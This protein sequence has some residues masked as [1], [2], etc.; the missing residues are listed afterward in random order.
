MRTVLTHEEY[1]HLEDA[2]N[3]IF[4]Q[5]PTKAEAR[6]NSKAIAHRWGWGSVRGWTE[7]K[8]RKYDHPATKDEIY[9]IVR[10]YVYG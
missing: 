8:L 2:V 4:G 1:G 9:R 6:G 5:R 7:R 10:Q 3:N